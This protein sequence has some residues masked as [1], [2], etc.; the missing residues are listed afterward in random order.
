M[1]LEQPIFIVEIR[2][3]EEERY[4][5]FGGIDFMSKFCGKYL[6]FKVNS[7]NNLNEE[8]RGGLFSLPEYMTFRGCKP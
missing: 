2:E 3:N 4:L 1:C 6:D 8:E 5:S 7:K